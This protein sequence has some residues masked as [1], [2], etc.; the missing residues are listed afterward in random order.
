MPIES[1]SAVRPPKYRRRWVI[2]L[3]WLAIALCA[4]LLAV[5]ALFAPGIGV[6]DEFGLG[7]GLG[8]AG[9]AALGFSIPIL[10][11]AAY[12]LIQELRRSPAPPLPGPRA[13]RGDW[14]VRDAALL[15][16]AGGL[17]LFWGGE[18]LWKW[19]EFRFSREVADLAAPGGKSLAFCD[20][21]RNGTDL[22]SLIGRSSSSI[23]GWPRD[24]SWPVSRC[25]SRLGDFDTQPGELALGGAVLQLD[26]NAGDSRYKGLAETDR[27]GAVTTLEL[28]RISASTAGAANELEASALTGNPQAQYRLAATL[29]EAGRPEEAAP[30]LARAAWQGHVD[31]MY[32]LAALKAEGKAIPEDLVGAYALCISASQNGSNEAAAAMSGLSRRMGKAE[33]DASSKR[34][35][36]LLAAG[37]GSGQRT[38]ATPSGS[39]AEAAAR[40]LRQEVHRS[41]ATL[42][43]LLAVLGGPGVLADHEVAETASRRLGAMGPAAKEAV[44]GLS[45]LIREGRYSEEP[46]QGYAK[47]TAFQALVQIGPDSIAEI[48]GLTRSPDRLVAY[49]APFALEFIYARQRQERLGRAAVIA[50]C[51]EKGTPAAMAALLLL[52]D[53][54]PNKRVKAA[55]SLAL[56]DGGDSV[57]VLLIALADPDAEIRAA[58]VTALGSMGRRAAASVPALGRML[59]EC[60]SET[61]T[62]RIQVI[63]PQCR[64]VVPALGGI[65][66]A[67]LPALDRLL[68][69]CPV[70][71]KDRLLTLCAATPPALGRIGAAAVPALKKVAEWPDEHLAAQAVDL[72]DSMGS[73]GREALGAASIKSP[74]L[75]DDARRRAQRPSRMPGK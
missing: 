23:D 52:E 26:I 28:Y 2:T 53:G 10:V 16:A 58:A 1:P 33:L 27:R 71:D 41:S 19:R 36:R 25:E 67:S 6:R 18:A 48:E 14:Q 69:K 20:A 64:G 63:R 17:A 72:L 39:D 46:F 68:D 60:L 75:R 13:V 61:N 45:R 38:R 59:E 50:R 32:E 34:F 44:P 70:P 29:R 9:F 49:S 74:T 40:A 66:P 55:E 7:F 3:S 37:V 8:V 4:P 57:E 24:K 22:W 15:L 43:D 30:W 47:K 11:I 35:S 65:G 56:L 5:G 62:L 31:A 21:L 51:R 54:P 42:A 73:A 12:S